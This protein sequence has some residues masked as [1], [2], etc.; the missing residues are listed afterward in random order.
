MED[1]CLQP[2]Q[3]PLFVEHD[4]VGRVLQVVEL[5]HL[6]GVLAA[7]RRLS[8]GRRDGDA[9]EDLAVV[10]DLEQ[11]LPDLLHVGRDDDE[12]ALR[13]ADED[14]AVAEPVVGH[15]VAVLGLEGQLDGVLGVEEVKEVERPAADDEAD[16]VLAGRAL[17]L[18]HFGELSGV[19]QLQ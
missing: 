6:D 10:L 18:F 14:V 16:R 1:Q 4:H 13:E 7:A 5:V 3:T 12:E 11:L 2:T 9:G 15:Y 17:V 8:D 19:A